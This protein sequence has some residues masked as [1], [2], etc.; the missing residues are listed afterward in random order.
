MQ[1]MLLPS[2]VDNMCFNPQTGNS[3][4]FNSYTNVSGIDSSF[5]SSLYFKNEV[6]IDILYTNADVLSK[7]KMLELKQ[8]ANNENPHIISITEVYPKSSLF[9]ITRE[10]YQIDGYDCFIS[11]QDK[12]RGIII[13]VRDDLK[14]H[15]VT[16]DK[17]NQESVWCEIKLKNSDKLLLG[18]IYRSPQMTCKMCFFTTGSE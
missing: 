12:G 2:R 9:E 1:A 3:F 4:N 18:C 17:E 14:A 11:D 5:N 10:V 15:E 16:I 6:D 13:Y 8:M 7:S